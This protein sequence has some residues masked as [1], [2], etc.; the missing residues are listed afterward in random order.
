V[1]VGQRHTGVSDRASVRR[2][3]LRAVSA[4]AGV[5]VACAKH[6]EEALTRPGEA[7]PP[8]IPAIISAGAS[9][10]QAGQP[11]VALGSLP[12]DEQAANKL[13]AQYEQAAPDQARQMLNDRS[14]MFRSNYRRVPDAVKQ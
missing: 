11:P 6:G 5:P 3:G 9:V 8:R 2:R 7:G 13:G 10:I 14:D 4:S 1:G 12:F